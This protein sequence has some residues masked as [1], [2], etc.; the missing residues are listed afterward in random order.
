MGF[1]RA[2]PILHRYIAGTDVAQNI[3]LLPGD[4]IFVPEESPLPW[5]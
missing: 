3:L 4:Q 1:A 2:Q 5:R